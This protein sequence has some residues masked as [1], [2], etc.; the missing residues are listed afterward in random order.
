MPFSDTTEQVTSATLADVIDAFTAHYPDGDVDLLRRAHETAEKAHEGQVRKTGDPYITHPTTVAFML[1]QYGLDVDTIAAAFLHDT[2]EDTPLTLA[3]VEQEFGKDIAML[4]DGVTKLDRVRYSNRERAQAASIRKMVVAMARD[5]R[6]LIIKLFDRL[7]N[8]RTVY[9]LREEKQ[10]R[11]ARETL[12]VYA[13]LA[14]RLGVQEIKHEFEDRCFAILYPGPN[15]EIQAKLAEAA[16]E[17]E[18][19]IEKMVTEISG[20][21]ADG[22][23]QAEVTGRPKHQFSIYRKML[24]QNRPFEEIHDLIGIRIVTQNTRDCYA[25]LGLVHSHWVPVTGRFKDYVAMPKINLYQSLHTTIIGPDGKPLEVQIRTVEMHRRAESGIAAHWRYKEGD[26]DATPLIDLEAFDE[27]PEEFLDNLKMDLYMDEVFV[28][29][30]GGDVKELPKG[31]TPVDFAYAVHTEVGHRCVGAKVNGRLVPLSTKLDSGDIVEV[32]TSNSQDAAPSRDWLKFVRTGKSRNKIRQWF[33]KERR[34]QAISEGKD[35]LAAL[36]KKEA[37]ELNA[38]EANRH[39]AAIA[40]ELG[41]RDVEAL[42]VGLGEGNVSLDSVA[43]RLHRRL[44]PQTGDDLFQP[45]RR[46]RFSESAHVVVEGQDDMLVSLAQCCA[47][48]PGDPIVGYVTVGRGV[49][50]HRSDCTNVAS[51]SARRERSVEVSWPS[52]A[53]GAFVVWIQVEALDRARLLRDVTTVVSDTGGNITASST[54][55]GED[56]VAVLKYEVELSDPSQLPRLLNDIRSV[57]GVYTAFRLANDPA[58]P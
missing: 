7:H 53:A 58:A 48:V 14:H 21:M 46:R 20:L 31:S 33:Q 50:V 10:K 56:R 35:Q 42:Q 41:Q 39:L 3:G 40:E 15:A 47:P 52:D 28:L 18:A 2:V 19:F 38:A 22:G 55:T 32:I 4:I 54:N 17:R 45:T 26:I 13:P 30:P 44:E 27:D 11:V 23:I 57:D 9:A 24:E 1:A 49:S 25:A 34:D 37:P 5:V 8:L 16:P 12:D 6:V 36:L 51:L 43:V 29:T